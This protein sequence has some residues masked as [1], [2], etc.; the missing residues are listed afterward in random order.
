[1]TVRTY[2]AIIVVNAVKGH[3]YLQLSIDNLHLLAPLLQIHSSINL[4]HVRLSTSSCPCKA[5]LEAAAINTRCSILYNK[6]YVKRG[7]LDYLIN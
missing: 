1:M 7:Y 4:Y 5:V 6:V 2:H 3:S